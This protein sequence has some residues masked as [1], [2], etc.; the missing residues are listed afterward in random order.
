M[1]AGISMWY[2]RTA[3]TPSNPTG[4]PFIAHLQALW[5]INGTLSSKAPELLVPQRSEIIPPSVPANGATRG[6]CPAAKALATSYTTA[7]AGGGGAALLCGPRMAATNGSSVCPS[8][9]CCS[10]TAAAEV[11]GVCLQSAIA[12]QVSLVHVLLSHL[13]AE[14]PSCLPPA[15]HPLQL[16]AG[17]PT[18][19][20]GVLLQGTSSAP[21]LVGYGACSAAAA[22]P[23]SAS[24]L[25]MQE[26][27]D[28]ASALV[29]L[30]ASQQLTW[31][32]LKQYCRYR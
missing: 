16:F 26:L 23:E 3:N 4:A 1:L 8:Y 24:T 11:A 17:M 2:R 28:G 12:C 20:V 19:C 15:P 9:A 6:S 5:A 29:L 30:D 10:Q 31:S 13:R 14:A 7:S 25:M 22:A 27:D 32:G 21:C 18:T